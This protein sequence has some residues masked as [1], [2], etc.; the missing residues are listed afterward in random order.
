MSTDGRAKISA[1]G[2]IQIGGVEISFSN[3]KNDAV[4]LNVPQLISIR[5]ELLRR[6][7]EIDNEINRR[8][9]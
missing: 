9:T 8:R 3:I 6:I 5:D 2:K 4:S 7:E 1:S